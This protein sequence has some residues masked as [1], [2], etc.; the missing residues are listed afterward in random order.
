MANQLHLRFTSLHHNT[1]QEYSQTLVSAGQAPTD[2]TH[3]GHQQISG[4]ESK[5]FKK[6]NFGAF[7]F[8]LKGFKFG[9][10]YLQIL[11]LFQDEWGPP[12]DIEI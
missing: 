5:S 6:H 9:P 3:H 10:Q 12:A 7:F 2:L 11:Y 1:K 4:P 8:F